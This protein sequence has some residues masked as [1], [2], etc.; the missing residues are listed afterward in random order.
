MAITVQ[1][2][3]DE[4]TT[5]ADATKWVIDD[6]ERLHVVGPS[7]NIASY[8]RG[9][10]A[11]VQERGTRN[12]QITAVATLITKEHKGDDQNFL[13]FNAD[14]SDERNKEWAKHT[15]ALSL[16]LTVIDSVAE[17]FEQ[18]GRYLLTFE[19]QD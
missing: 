5:H 9:Y 3:K 1:H 7:G 11:N 13:A 19:K 16:S 17:N 14:Y 8:N 12:S 15:P 18:G 2:G 6:S 10:W 4:V